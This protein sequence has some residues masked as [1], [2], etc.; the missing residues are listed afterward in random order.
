MNNARYLLDND[1]DGHWYL[2]PVGSQEAFRAYVESE[3]EDP[4]PAG[5]IS[6]GSH[7]NTVTFERPEH[8]GEP[9][10]ATA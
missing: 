5:V 2:L 8:F 7:P 10:E 3:G 9:V 6:L 1:D 4:Y